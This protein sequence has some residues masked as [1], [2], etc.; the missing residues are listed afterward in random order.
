MRNRCID[1]ANNVVNGRHI[2]LAVYRFY[3]STVAAPLGAF[4]LRTVEFVF[5]FACTSLWFYIVGM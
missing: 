4:S 3:M 5:E 1:D 2:P